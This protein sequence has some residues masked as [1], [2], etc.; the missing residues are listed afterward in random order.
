MS[1]LGGV[2][3]GSIAVMLL[4]AVPIGMVIGSH[5]RKRRP[6][7]W[8]V[9]YSWSLL[10]TVVFTTVASILWPE[11]PRFLDGVVF[12]I[13]VVPIAFLPDVAYTIR[14][15]RDTEPAEISAPGAKP[16][17]NRRIDL[18]V[19]G[20]GADV[21][22]H[23]AD[24]MVRARYVIAAHRRGLISDTDL[25]HAAAGLGD[26]S[27]IG[28]D[29]TQEQ[30]DADVAEQ[31][32][33]YALRTGD[34]RRHREALVALEPTVDVST[35]A[36]DEPEW[37]R[38][39]RRERLREGLIDYFDA[40]Y[41]PQLTETVHTHF[42]DP[43]V[44]AH[45]LIAAYRFHATPSGDVPQRAAE[46]IADLPGAGEAW[47]EL[48]MAPPTS[49]RSDIEPILDRAADEIGYCR[50]PAEAERDL[51]EAAAYRAVVESSV[52]DEARR[53]WEL[54][55]RDDVYFEGAVDPAL[56]ALLWAHTA[57]GD[58]ID[59]QIRDTRHTL[60]AY[61]NGRY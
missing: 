39:H 24:P 7:D 52:S 59:D 50:T 56:T 2:I 4:V 26:L 60:I 61:L 31:L 8:I 34:A 40:R 35:R 37:M 51:Y 49:A 25:P 54:S 29:R 57:A 27:E 44:R 1:Y 14:H 42:A 47:T 19:A 23:F 43:T 18:P 9:D 15:R 30:A 32:I 6:K 58:D 45:A 28:Y 16:E 11:R 38:I 55:M 17:R 5:D 20:F 46:L 53:L 21:E 3:V 22:A 12:G 41:G 48:A 13:A 33:Y 10:W 36:R